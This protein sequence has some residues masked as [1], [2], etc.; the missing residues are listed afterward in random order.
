MIS[1]ESVGVEISNDRMAIAYVK[2]TLFSTKVHAHAVYDLNGTSRLDE[3]MDTVSAK[4]KDF[5]RQHR[6]GS[7]CV[8]MGLR[9]R[10]W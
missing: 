10:K 2:A 1:K 7:A 4:V 3:K 6:I 8:W 9:R 5:L